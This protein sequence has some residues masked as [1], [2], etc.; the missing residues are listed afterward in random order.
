MEPFGTFRLLAEPH[1]NDKCFNKLQITHVV[2]CLFIENYTY[3]F[4]RTLNSV[5]ALHRATINPSIVI[6]FIPGRLLPIHWSG[7]LAPY[8]YKWLGTKAP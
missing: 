6:N 7:A 1:P 5:A 4:L 3:K 8:F 2:H